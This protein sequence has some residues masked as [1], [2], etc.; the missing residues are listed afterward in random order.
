[1]DAF[2]SELLNLWTIVRTIVQGVSRMIINNPAIIVSVF[3]LVVS[4][5]SFYVSL[6]N[7]SFQRDMELIQKLQIFEGLFYEMN[8]P[9]LEAMN[10]FT[11]EATNQAENWKPIESDKFLKI[12][13]RFNRIGRAVVTMYKNV[14]EIVDIPKI[15]LKNQLLRYERLKG[16][17]EV[18]KKLLERLK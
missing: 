5:L 12:M 13:I 10:Y 3:A 15:S 9:L 11:K 4:N 17:I 1:M 16:D 2:L 18:S 8:I 6:R 7:S 14:E